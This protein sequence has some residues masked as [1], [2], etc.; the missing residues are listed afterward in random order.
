M[1]RPHSNWA[2]GEETR[3]R[4]VGVLASRRVPLWTQTEIGDALGVSY[5][6]VAHHLPILRERG[7]VDWVDGKGRT[8]HLTREGWESAS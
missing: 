8:I 4:I 3:E 7:L 2:Q 5:K 1:S 6:A